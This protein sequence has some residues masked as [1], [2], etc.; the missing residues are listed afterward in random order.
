MMEET[1]FQASPLQQ[2]T[3]AIEDTTLN[4]MK[5]GDIVMHSD[6]SSS[7]LVEIREKQPS[8]W[9][10][11]KRTKRRNS[12]E[13]LVAA[14]QELYTRIDAKLECYNKHIAETETVTKEK[15]VELDSI[16]EALA[17]LKELESMYRGE[18][19]S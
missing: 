13:L 7:R 10:P 8:I 12:D 11:I 5:V 6:G 18:S 16:F 14:I 15:S 19:N 4:S 9:E 1:L 2:R 17:P 3:D